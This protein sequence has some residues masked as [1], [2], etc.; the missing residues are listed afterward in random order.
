M[1]RGQLIKQFIKYMIGGGVYFW[2]GYAVFAICYSGFGW[3]WLP[4]KILAD[5][6]GWT[7]SFFI[8]RYW[9]F[10][11][12]SLTGKAVRVTSRYVLVNAANFVID[13]L[14]VWGLTAVGISPYIGLFV[15][16]GFFTVWNYL[17]YRF[18]VFGPIA[19]PKK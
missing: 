12:P 5:I 11:H 17:W 18:W 6:I 9:A 1:T 7:L 3:D 2:S 19:A 13:Y 8:Q 16:A 14:I 10:S 4:A 15:A